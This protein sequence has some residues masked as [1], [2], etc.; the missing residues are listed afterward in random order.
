MTSRDRTIVVVLAVV[1]AIAAAWLLVISPKRDQASKLGDQIKAEQAQLTNA[2]SDVAA[3]E[4]ARR[5][6]ATSYTALVRLGEAVPADDNVPSLIYQIQGAAH[7]ADVDFRQLQL[8]PG[9]AGSASTAPAS[10]SSA[11]QA[12]TAP[13]PPGATVGPA[14]F[15][16]EPFTFSFQG[17]FFHLAN[18]FGRLQRFVI[19]SNKQVSV[20]GRLM[21]LNSISL[22]PGPK[23]FPQITASISATTYLVPA[24]QGLTNGATASSPGSSSTQQVSTPATSTP[25][26]TAVVASPVR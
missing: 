12:S 22:S 23:G 7:A 13:L 26:P 25:A 9:S 21:T 20:S 15:P 10:S 19:A 5:A 2:Q 17:N 18:F 8:A 4:A 6:Y 11:T 1:A 16:I 3:G 14:G 24:A